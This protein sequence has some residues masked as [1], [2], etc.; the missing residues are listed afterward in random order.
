[1]IQLSTKKQEN[2]VEGRT[3]SF[4]VVL[5]IVTNTRGDLELFMIYCRGNRQF[6]SHIA[7]P[8]DMVE[9]GVDPIVDV[10]GY[11][12]AKKVTL[13]VRNEADADE[14]INLAKV[15]LDEFDR[16]TKNAEALAP[17]QIITINA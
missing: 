8:V 9:Y 13:V 3:Q 5:E 17:E 7:S 6:F 11:Y 15:D 2:Y 14:V 12:R 10:E 16:S 4:T 1:M